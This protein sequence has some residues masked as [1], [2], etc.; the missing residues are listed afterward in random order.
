[1]KGPLES[2]PEDP[3]PAMTVTPIDT[4]RTV[5]R[6]RDQHAVPAG[7]P[8]PATGAR[9]AG[10]P[11]STR[12]P[13]PAAVTVRADI[14]PY[15]SSSG[16]SH[17]GRDRS[18]AA[19]RP[20][21][22]APAG[23]Q[24]VDSISYELRD[25]AMRRRGQRAGVSEQGTADLLR[26]VGLGEAEWPRGPVPRRGST[27]YVGSAT[28]GTSATRPGRPGTRNV[29]ARDRWGDRGRTSSRDRV[30]DVRDQFSAQTPR[31]RRSTR[32]RCLHTTTA[33]VYARRQCDGHR[34]CDGSIGI[35]RA[36]GPGRAWSSTGVPAIRAR[37]SWPGWRR[38]PTKL[39]YRRVCFRF[40]LHSRCCMPV[41]KCRH[42]LQ[43]YIVTT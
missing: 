28:T 32:R 9:S 6:T 37:D 13:T 22:V 11:T 17:P 30:A 4:T 12:S 16:A 2:S 7:W 43:C 20:A 27:Q 14:A 42:Y 25:R 18:G 38:R 21:A 19:R 33:G 35:S 10:R 3:R 31:S 39:I 34:G 40:A 8:D 5:Q 1:M 24:G 36:R 23:P 41:G 26:A 29:Y 15:S